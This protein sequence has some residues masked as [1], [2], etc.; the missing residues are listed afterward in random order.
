MTA[1]AGGTPMY[2]PGEVDFRGAHGMLAQKVYE[3]RHRPGGR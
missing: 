2:A 3:G 1:W